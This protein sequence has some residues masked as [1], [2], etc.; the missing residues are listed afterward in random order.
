MPWWQHMFAMLVLVHMLWAVVRLQKEWKRG[1]H[2]GDLALQPRLEI[3]IEQAVDGARTH[4][5]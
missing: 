5:K 4:S 3:Y 2:R 1:R